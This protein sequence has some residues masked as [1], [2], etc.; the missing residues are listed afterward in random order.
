MKAFMDTYVIRIYRRDKNDP[1]ML[2]GVVE[3]VGVE[4]NRAFGN[5]DELWSVLNSSRARTS[6]GKKRNKF[7]NEKKAWE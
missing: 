5:L 1:R 6:K 3:E 4:G 2:I 7:L